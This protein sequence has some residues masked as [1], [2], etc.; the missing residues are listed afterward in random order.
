MLHR[1]LGLCLV[2]ADPPED[3]RLPVLNEVWKVVMKLKHPAVSQSQ[4]QVVGWL[5]SV[6]MNS[7]K[8]Q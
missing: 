7:T 1:S 3:Q 6:Q 4:M 8:N 5:K 2:M